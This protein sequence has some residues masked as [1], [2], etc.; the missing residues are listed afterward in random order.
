MS[1]SRREV[2]ES[3]MLTRKWVAPMQRGMDWGK[4]KARH[5]DRLVL[6]LGSYMTRIESEASDFN[7]QQTLGGLP[8]WY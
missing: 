5:M 7:F 4:Y 1:T 6:F 8:S 2:L 3:G